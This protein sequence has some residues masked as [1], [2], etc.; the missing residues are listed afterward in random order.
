MF[1]NLNSHPTLPLGEQGGPATRKR[2]RMST[3]QGNSTHRG[4]RARRQRSRAALSGQEAALL[5]CLHCLF[6]WYCHQPGEVGT[7]P[8]VFSMCSVTSVE[9][10]F[11][12]FVSFPRASGHCQCWHQEIIVQ[13]W[14]NQSGLAVPLLY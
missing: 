10:P 5:L 4:V 14:L 6:S 3:V 12:V 8:T 7:G 13:H 11:F 1:Q 2:L 9:G